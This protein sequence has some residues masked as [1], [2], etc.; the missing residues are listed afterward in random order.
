M[1][2]EEAQRFPHSGLWIAAI[3]PPPGVFDTGGAAVQWLSVEGGKEET[4]PVVLRI[5]GYR[6]S[7]YE[8]DLD[9]PPHVHVGKQG[10][11][12]KYWM[13]PIALSSSR[14]FRDHEL[15]EIEKIL[16]EHQGEILDA[17][18][19]EQQKRGNR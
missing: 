17:W 16:A 3:W 8:A 4:M 9:E 2:S 11:E 5:R 13:S 10:Q 12:A 15:N 1:G 19:R 6:F 14:G 18:Q 7:F